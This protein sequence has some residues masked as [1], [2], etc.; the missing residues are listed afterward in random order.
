MNTI[1]GTTALRPIASPERSPHATAL[2]GAWFEAAAPGGSLR[3]YA[4]GNAR[5]AADAAVTLGRCDALLDAL[6]AWLGTVLD[7]RWLAASASVTSTTSHARAH[8]RPDEA[9]GRKDLGC[10]LELPWSLLRAAPAPDEAL[11]R[12]LQWADV[13]VVLSIAQLAIGRDELALLEPGGAVI[14]PASMQPSWHGALRTVDESCAPANGAPVALASPWSPRRI[15]AGARLEARAEAAGDRVLCEVRL[16]IRH[17]VPADRLAG[18][19]E[20][21]FGDVG[22]RAGLWRCANDREPATCLANGQLMPWGDGWALVI[23]DL[24]EIRQAAS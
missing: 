20:G 1:V 21:E 11:A 6:D 23:G 15:K 5:H 18:W 16:G 9:K 7:W 12:Q 14:L 17:A 22:P 19:F 24:Y 13:P 8:W 4:S 2:A 3:L 10:R